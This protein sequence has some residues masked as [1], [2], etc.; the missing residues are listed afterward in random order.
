M[1]FV[2]T[3][4][5]D[6]SLANPLY[7]GA[8]VTIYTVDD[9]GA[10]AAVKATLYAS[11]TGSTT[12]S[13]PQ[14]LDSEGKWQQPVYIDT[15]VTASVSGLTIADHDTGV[16]DTGG[17]W[18]GDWQ[19]G[20]V[21]YAN[22]IVRDGVNGD[23]TLDL[24]IVISQHA[25]GAWAT[26]RA[27]ATKMLLALDTSAITALASLPDPA[28]A[29]ALDFLRVNAARTGYEFR[30]AHEM[31][32]QLWTKGAD[33]ASAATLTPGSD[34]NYF[35]VTGTTS[36][37]AIAPVGA[38]A[39]I[40]L[41]FD[42]ALTLTHHATNL[43]LPGAATITTAA[44]DHAIFR[45]YASAGWRCAAYIRG[46]D[47]PSL[48]GARTIPLAARSWKP[49]RTN[50]C[51]ALALAESSTNDVMTEYL[52]FSDSIIQY[53]QTGFR[54]PKSVDHSAAISGEIEWTEASGAT[55]HD[56]V[57]QVEMQMQGA[58]DTIDS[59]WGAAVTATDTGTSGA[60]RFASFTA[61]TPAGGPANRDRLLVRLARQATDGSDTLDVKANFIEMHLDLTINA[62]NDA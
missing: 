25:S 3:S 60:R 52:G 54:L 59:A 15:P 23:G 28:A 18:R 37:T 46:S 30:S 4:I 32:G 14:T 35:D 44:G 1:V 29:A 43:I 9:T 51:D 17:A 13:N 40:M 38:G 56:C 16:I 49:Q 20:Q 24:Y 2:R 22:D 36:I 27:D 58:G 26:D 33:I 48:Q 10:K 39:E 42:A 6:F 50:G 47:L 5:A 41:Q 55:L 19:T 61:V 62:G 53:A 31:R 12:L 34:G 8:T 21:Y 57:W 45:E 11:P 7:A